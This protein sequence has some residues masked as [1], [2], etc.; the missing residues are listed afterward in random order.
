MEV[1]EAVCVPV[2]IFLENMNSKI[3]NNTEARSFIFLCYFFS[4]SLVFS[5]SCLV[6]VVWIEPERLCFFYHFP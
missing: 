5:S 2:R 3:Y 4:L 1:L 6:E